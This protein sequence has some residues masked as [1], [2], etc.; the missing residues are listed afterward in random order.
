MAPRS[1]GSSACRRGPPSTRAIWIIRCSR[2]AQ[3]SRRSVPPALTRSR[4]D[5]K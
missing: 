1:A 2:W 5:T 4:R 3:S